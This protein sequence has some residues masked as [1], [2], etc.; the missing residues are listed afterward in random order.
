LSRHLRFVSHIRLVLIDALGASILDRACHDIAPRKDIRLAVNISPLQLNNPAFVDSLVEIA[1]RNGFP[2]DRLDIE[3]TE[4]L[5]IKYPERA[6]MEIAQI[7]ALGVTVS[8][9]DFGTG[10][11]SVGYLRAFSFNSVKLDR[12]LSNA[13]LNDESAQQVVQGT[14]MIAKGLSATTVAEGVETL[15]E[16]DIMRLLGCKQLQG[17]YYGRPAALEDLPLFGDAVIPKIASVG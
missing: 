16:S 10:F 6:K 14:I 7:Q 5:L 15:A 4:H 8:L 12:S 11:A 2:L 9:D 3:I 17:F 13:I 1:A